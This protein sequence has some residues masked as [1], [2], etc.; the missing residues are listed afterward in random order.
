MTDLENEIS[1]SEPSIQYLQQLLET[2]RN[3]TVRVPRFQ[4]P[5]IWQED[6]QL[7]L[8]RSIREGIPIGSVMIWRTTDA[9]VAYYE[10]LGNFPISSKKGT[11][12]QQ[13]IL[14]GVQRVCT[15][16]GALT[17]WR[18]LPEIS[19]NFEDENDYTNK[20]IYFSFSD[21]D[22]VFGDA[23]QPGQDLMPL[24]VVFDSLE[25]IDFQRQL[26]EMG[27][28]SWVK[29]SA[30]IAT[31]F[32]D[33]KIPII[34]ITTD[35]LSVATSTFQRIN[36]QGAKMSDLHMI[37]ALTWSNGFDLQKE[38]QNLREEFLNPI[39][40]GDLED[41]VM[42]R[43]CKGLRGLNLYKTEPKEVSKLLR[44]EPHLLRQ[45]AILI[46]RTANIFKHLFHINRPDFAPYAFQII[47]IAIAIESYDCTE[48]ELENLIHDWFW[49]TTYAE[50]FSGMS[51]DK[52]KHALDDFQA[53]LKTRTPVWSNEKKKFVELLPKARFDFRSARSKATILALASHR[54]KE[55]PSGFDDLSTF[56]RESIHPLF[57]RELNAADASS[58]GN[59]LVIDPESIREFR[60]KWQQN[61]LTP[62]EL[63]AH[64][65][66]VHEMEQSNLGRQSDVIQARAERIFNYEQQLANRTA[67]RFI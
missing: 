2:V 6:R 34:A 46:S 21:N 55:R 52:V 62:Q 27:K 26:M 67:A 31:R 1:Y 25:L 19:N 3:G 24:S 22:F 54:S 64:F 41:E 33:Y 66:N 59:K 43:V 51:D 28:S 15:L 40:W 63:E 38:L 29:Q 23:N 20:I 18:S 58:P 13:Y 7:E 8:M 32:R 53:M 50:A 10:R 65:F 47:F 30:I 36:S 12:P 5:F 45:A 35:D 17:P 37:H 61:L 11:R 48:P 56:G 39:L 44:N 57:V 16:Y 49:F 60:L 4:R 9:P 42:L 14:D